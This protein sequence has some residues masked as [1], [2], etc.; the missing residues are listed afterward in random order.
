MVAFFLFVR[1]AIRAALGCA[2][3]FDL[4]RL[5]VRL[6][7]PLKTRNDRRTFVRA[8]L[9][10]DAQGQLAATPLTRQGSGALTSM[11]GANA[12]LEVES[13]PRQFVVGDELPALVIGPLID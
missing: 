12:L 13:G 7:A 4:P 11:R 3:P 10:V 2:Q 5:R 9:A 6:A 8:R 1:P